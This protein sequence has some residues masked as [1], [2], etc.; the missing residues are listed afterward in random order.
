MDKLEQLPPSDQKSMNNFFMMLPGG[1]LRKYRGSEPDNN[2]PSDKGRAMDKIDELLRDEFPDI[3][4]REIIDIR[5]DYL[6]KKASQAQYDESQ[7]KLRR[8]YDRLIELGYDENVLR[9]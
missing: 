4:P 1:Y 8:L 3:D 6:D 5:N 7:A 2:E 9:R